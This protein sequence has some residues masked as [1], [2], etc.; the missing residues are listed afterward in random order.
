MAIIF[1]KFVDYVINT[2]KVK[3]RSLYNLI[4]I[5]QNKDYYSYVKEKDYH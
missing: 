4:L 5:H 1:H 3:F 2:V